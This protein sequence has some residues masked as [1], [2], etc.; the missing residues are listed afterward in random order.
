M[1]FSKEFLQD[2]G[3]ETV[4]NTITGKSRWAIHYR[5]VFKHEE[6]FYATTYSTGATEQQYDPPYEYEPDE[7]ECPEVWPVNKTVVVYE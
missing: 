1:L 6:K 3:G 4:E 2:D 5:R 7:I